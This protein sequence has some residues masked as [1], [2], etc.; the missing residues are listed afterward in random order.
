MIFRVASDCN[1]FCNVPLVCLSSRLVPPTT[2]RRTEAPKTTSGQGEITTEEQE[3][4]EEPPED[5]T[6]LIIGLSVTFGLLFL[7]IVM[8]SLLYWRKGR[9]GKEDLA[10]LHTGMETT[11][12]DKDFGNMNFALQEVDTSMFGEFPDDSM[13][14]GAG[15]DNPM[16]SSPSTLPIDENSEA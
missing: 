12:Y 16:Y 8:I 13:P 15:I 6:A 14:S 3:A 4:S 7:I 10:S 2:K 5:N 11:G 1:F 9:R